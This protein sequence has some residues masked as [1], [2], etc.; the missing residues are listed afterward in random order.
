MDSFFPIEQKSIAQGILAALF[1]GLG[2]GIG[3]LLGGYILN[4]YG[5]IVLFQL[6][7]TIC[8]FSLAV[9]L[10]GRR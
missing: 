2:Y 3:C 9:F 6:S 10:L 7:A 4:L 1:S 5:Q 8:G